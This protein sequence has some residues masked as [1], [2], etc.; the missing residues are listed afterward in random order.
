LAGSDRI[1]LFS[2]LLHAADISNPCKPWNLAQR[3]STLLLDELR[4]QGECEVR[5]GLAITPNCGPDVCIAKFSIGFID[6]FVIPLFEALE[7]WLPP[8]YV[9]N[10]QLHNNR[11]AWAK[12]RAT[13]EN[14][15]EE[16][17]Q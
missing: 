9:A 16:Q 2:I 10:E 14:A 3:W 12:I 17:K 5:E 6:L 8:L 7:K 4:L 13:K 1:N 15:S 11:E